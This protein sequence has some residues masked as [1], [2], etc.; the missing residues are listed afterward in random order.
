MHK[1]R[2]LFVIAALTV[3]TFAAC[4][5]HDDPASER[6]S[7]GTLSLPLVTTSPGGIVYRLTASFQVTGTGVDQLIDASATTTAVSVD[8]P[9]GTYQLTLLDGWSISEQTTG[10]SVPVAA[11]LG[12]ANPITFSVTNQAV[13]D[14]VWQFLVGDDVI[15]FGQGRASISFQ[16][17]D[18]TVPPGLCSAD[19]AACAT[20][21][22]C[23][24]APITGHC[25]LRDDAAGA[26]CVY[27]TRLDT[28]TTLT[29][30]GL[31]FGHCASAG[32]CPTGLTCGY[33]GSNWCGGTT[34]DGICS[35]SWAQSCTTD[36]ECTLTRPNICQI[37]GDGVLQLAATDCT[38]GRDCQNEECDDGN[39]VDGDGC[40]ASCKYE[41]SCVTSWGWDT[42]F[43][44]G[45]VADCATNSTCA[46]D[47]CTCAL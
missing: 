40:S 36:A 43:G 46:Y 32:D 27:D 4:A 34:A 26:G 47:T 5:S 9:V 17:N 23:V 7:G 21:A 19:A 18:G 14:V 31:T 12:N 29:C 8:L 42:G 25:V 10:G 3:P 2:T 15:E 39:T 16:V 22:D 38:D 45:T 33:Y 6:V 30:E 11:V 20:D 44:C 37:C 28:G 24:Q 1:L 13:T 41:G 35:L